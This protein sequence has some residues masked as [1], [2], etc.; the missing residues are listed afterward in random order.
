MHLVTG[1]LAP[2]D[3]T[4]HNLQGAQ[5]DQIKSLPR[6]TTS[7]REDSESAEL[8]QPAASYS[9]QPQLPIHTTL[10]LRYWTKR[11]TIIPV[12]R[13]APRA[14]CRKHP[15]SPVQCPKKPLLIDPPSA[16]NPHHNANQQCH[17]VTSNKANSRRFATAAAPEPVLH[18]TINCN[19]AGSTSGIQF[20]VSALSIMIRIFCKVSQ[21]H[22]RVMAATHSASSGFDGDLQECR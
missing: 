2:L 14:F 5:I 19:P 3:G 6:A 18:D 16:S 9:S 20:S 11:Y 10:Q 8:I 1:W 17:T 7:R 15:R 12:A 22:V 4:L 21:A 13:A